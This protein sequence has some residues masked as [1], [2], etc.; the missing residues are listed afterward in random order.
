MWIC[1]DVIQTLYL[2][3]F[4]ILAAAITHLIIICFTTCYFC[5]AGRHGRAMGGGCALNGDAQRPFA[6]KSLI[7]ERCRKE[8]LRERRQLVKVMQGEKVMRWTSLTYY[9]REN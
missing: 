9:L 1:A 2:N 6:R 8:S 3:F 4:A 5:C 7:Y